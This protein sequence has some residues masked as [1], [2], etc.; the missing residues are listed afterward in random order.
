MSQPGTDMAECPRCKGEGEEYPVVPIGSG[1]IP[2]PGPCDL[3]SGYGAVEPHIKRWYERKGG[4][5]RG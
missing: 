4:P 3:C 5:R 1:L 2:E